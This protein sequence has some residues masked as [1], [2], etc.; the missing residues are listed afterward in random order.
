[1]KTNAF[2]SRAQEDK[3]SYFSVY[4]MYGTH[5]QCTSLAIL[6][7]NILKVTRD[8]RCSL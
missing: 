3:Q 8:I 7:E 1:M 4:D 6:N 2:Y 5:V